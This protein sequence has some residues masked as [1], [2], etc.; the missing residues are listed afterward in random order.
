MPVHR[1][2]SN[3]KK[4]MN[5]AVSANIRELAKQ[6]K[7]RSWKQIIAIAYSEAG[8]KKKMKKPGK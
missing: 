2:K 8:E 3:S 1:A 7:G 4:D 5:T 6:P